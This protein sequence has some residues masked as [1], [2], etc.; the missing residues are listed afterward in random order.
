MLRFQTTVA[1]AVAAIVASSAHAGAVSVTRSYSVDAGGKGGAADSGLSAAAT[2]RASGTSFSI[3]L[4]NTSTSAPSGGV[5]N[6]LLSTLAFNLPEGVGIASGNGATIAE[7]SRGIGGWDG[8]EAGD[9]VAEEWAY[10][11]GGAN[12]M[13]RDHSHA[14]TT[15]SK[16]G[17]A[18]QHFFG[19]A[20]PDLR[21]AF[22]G[23]ISGETASLFDFNGRRQHAVES[24]IVFDFTL[25][26][27]LTRDQLAAIADSAV[28]E[29]GRQ[30]QYL[31]AAAPTNAGMVIPLPGAAGLSVLG[32]GVA[33]S[34]RRR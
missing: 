15:D 6:A 12:H 7:G 26:M 11:E 4:R 25:T 30:F 29:F 23:L 9:S 34:R 10:T 28:A 3:T 17:R 13:L 31:S 5:A 21:N 2:F 14:I 33:A 20:L 22:G 1:M 8:R 19:G 24:A 16:I 18:Q 27:E 32:L